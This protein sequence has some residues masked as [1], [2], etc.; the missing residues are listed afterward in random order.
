[1]GITN[2][3]LE[4]N[5]IVKTYPGVVALNDVTIK[6]KK[7]EVHALVGEN[8]AG[9]STLIK[10]CT[11]AVTPNKGQIIVDGKKFT[12]MT[13]KSAEENGIAVIYQEF[14]NVGELSVAENIFLGRAIRKKGLMINK[15][16]MYEE[17]KK[18][19][20]QFNININPNELV[21]NLTVGY[22]QI[23][24]IAKAI[25]QKA[26]IL[27]MDEPSAPLT[28]SEVESMFAIV[29]KLKESGVT[30]IYISHRLDEIF[31]LTDRITVMRD[32]QKVKTINTRDTD[33]NEL[34]KLMVG[35]ELTE[36]YPS[37]RL[38]VK[39]EILLDVKDVCG[40]GLKDISF[41]IKRGEVLGFAGLIGS[42]RTELAELVFGVK[43][44]TQGEIIFMGKE[45]SPRTPR[46]AIDHGIALVPEDRKHQGALLDIDIKNNIS[47]AILNRISKGSVVNKKDENKIADKYKKQLK[48]KTP[49]LEQLVKNLSGGN[50]QKVILAKWL[51]TNPDLIILDEPT[52]GID[53]GAKYEIYKL[54][55]SMV[56]SGKTIWMISSEMEEIMGMSDRI[57]VLSEGKI[58]GTLNKHDFSQETIMSLASSV[59]G[60]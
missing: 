60:E 23:V 41:Q 57:I 37:R 25:S 49:S 4:L 21:K 55:N 11:G 27:I 32:G 13:P 29:D 31:R 58:S 35:R 7:G 9:K 38:A 28:K 10:T 24:E 51:A 39:D 30:I 12:S 50:Q 36:T 42:G 6:I 22:Q 18:I 43:Q 8:G 19:F 3:I 40:N 5:N 45:I 46:E 16:A 1:M 54:I 56:E 26:K 17:S 48:I 44:K 14:N 15:K 20:E 52:R 47:M 53:V 2:T 34:V 33:V 59:K